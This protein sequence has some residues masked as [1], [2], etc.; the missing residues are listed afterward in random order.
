MTLVRVSL[1][2]ETPSRKMTDRAGRDEV[3]EE[4]LRQILGGQVTVPEI[5]KMLNHN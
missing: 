5:Q 1:A 4:A 2:Q 3:L